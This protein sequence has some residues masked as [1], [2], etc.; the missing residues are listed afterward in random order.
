MRN[1]ITA[2][3]QHGTTRPTTL[4]GRSG[5]KVPGP[6]RA[7]PGERRASDVLSACAR[8]GPSCSLGAAGLSR[9]AA[10]VRGGGR[11]AR[12]ASAALA[13]YG[14]TPGAT[15]GPRG[16]IAGE[17]RPAAPG[18]ARSR[19][20]TYATCAKALPLAERPDHLGGGHAAGSARAPRRR[21]AES[22]S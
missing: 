6:R 10:P 3:T 17:V 7:E 21:A 5:G 15:V 20:S 22:S 4:N 1:A 18:P 2:P 19:A 14:R 9:G 11:V 8:R 12:L 13:R 16:P